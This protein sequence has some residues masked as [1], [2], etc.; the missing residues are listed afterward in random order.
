MLMKKF[1]KKLFGSTSII[2]TA[3]VPAEFPAYAATAIQ[4]I[5]ASN[6]RLEDEEIR[7]LSA[8]PL[9]FS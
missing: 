9:A 3:A 5:A 7:D 2:S 1:F 8:K 6:G 4:L